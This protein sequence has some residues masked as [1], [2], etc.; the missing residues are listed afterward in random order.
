MQNIW[1]RCNGNETVLNGKH[2][3]RSLARLLILEYLI[4]SIQSRAF[5][6]THNQ[7]DYKCLPDLQ[8]LAESLAENKEQAK[9]FG[10]AI[11]FVKPLK[12]DFDV[13][14]KTCEARSEVCQFLGILIHIISLMKNLVAADREGNW[15]RH[16]ATVSDAMPVFKECDCLHY[17]RNG[18]Y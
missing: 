8:R 13:F 10:E 6:L 3:Y 2:Y 5:F 12:D 17:L 11:A 18:G 14:L 4:V 16:V 9:E 7:K 1:I 15:D